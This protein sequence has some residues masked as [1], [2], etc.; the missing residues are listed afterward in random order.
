[1]TPNTVLTAHDMV[2]LPSGTPGRSTTCAV[3]RGNVEAGFRLG[4]V[5]Q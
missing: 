5:A 3:I 2:G 1:M 4:V